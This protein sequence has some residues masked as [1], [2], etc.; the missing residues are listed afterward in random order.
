MT[1]IGCATFWFVFYASY[2]LGFWYGVKLII[3]EREAC[4]GNGEQCDGGV[5]YDPSS[6]IKVIIHFQKRWKGLIINH[7]WIFRPIFDPLLQPLCRRHMLK[8]HLLLNLHV[9]TFF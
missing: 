9:S 8:L 7:F 2:G 1:A 3:D 6:L 4:G 5:R